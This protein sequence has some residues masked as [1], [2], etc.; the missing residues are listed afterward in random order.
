MICAAD[1]SV[2]LDNFD[3]WTHLVSLPFHFKTTVETIPADLPYL[4]ALPQR[5]KKW[6]PRIPQRGTRVGIVWKGSKYHLNDP[7]R[8]IGSLSAL[9]PLWQTGR[10]DLTFVSLQSG[11]GVEEALQ[12]A[13]SQPLIHLGSE[14]EDF[15]DTAAILAQLDLLIC[16][17]TSVAHL[18]GAM[19]VPCWVMLTCRH[20]DWRWLR[21]RSDSPWYPH[22]MRLFWQSTT[23]DWTRVIAEIA[24]ALKTFR[25]TPREPAEQRVGD[26]YSLDAVAKERCR[27]G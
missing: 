16:V 13:T 1:G 18:A 8:S 15:A 11:N 21:A 7:N 19:N 5:L 27:R 24:E 17:D 26:S 2:I 10:S 23:G 20:T 3:Y 6:A 12:P 14:L 9:A 22:V 25:V 4:F